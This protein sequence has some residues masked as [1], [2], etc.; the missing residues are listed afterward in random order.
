[1]LCKCRATHV[2][3][4]ISDAEF[5]GDIHFKAWPEERSISGQT[6]VKKVRFKIQ[7]FLTKVCLSCEVWSQDSKNV[8]YFHVRHL[9]MPKIAFQKCDVITFFYFFFGHCTVKNKDIALRFCFVVCLHFYHIYSRSLDTSKNDFIGNF[10]KKS[11]FWV[12]CVNIEK[13]KKTGIARL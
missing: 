2:L 7:N 4:V 12:L 1:M 9:E 5:H 11:K 3:W 13:Y 10:R 6:R 8:I